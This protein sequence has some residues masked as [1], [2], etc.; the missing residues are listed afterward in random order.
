MVRTP[1]VRWCRR[2][3]SKASV[4]KACGKGE[5]ASLQGC[6]ALA[7]GETAVAFSSCWELQHLDMHISST[8][9]RKTTSW[10]KLER[11]PVAAE[12]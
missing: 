3:I 11:Y 2:R 1:S 12:L 8:S 10:K 5:G 4:V 9:F 6:G 7:A